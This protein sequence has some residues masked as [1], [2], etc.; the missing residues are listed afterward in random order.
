M[1]RGGRNDVASITASAGI[2]IEHVPVDEVERL[3]PEPRGDRRARGQREH[4]A[5]QHERQQRRQHAGGRPSTTRSAK[6]VRS[7]RET[8]DAPP[9]RSDSP[10]SC[11]W[12]TERL[13][14]PDATS[15]RSR[16]AAPA[17]AR[18][19]RRRAPRNC[20][21]GRTTRRPATAAPPAPRRRP[22]RRRAPRAQPRDRACRRPRAAT[23]P[24]SCGA[25]SAAAS[26]IR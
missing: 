10:D 11:R 3:E 23:W 15:H 1:W 4:D 7:T 8:M 18:G 25:N 21:T 9:D 19:R 12:L 13:T 5:G 6:G 24:S 26:P 20:G 17:P 16:P 2:R 22:P 14:R